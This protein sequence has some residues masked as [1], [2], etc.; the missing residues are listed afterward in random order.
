MKRIS[1]ILLVIVLALGSFS[2]AASLD[3]PSQAYIAPA[4]E[5]MSLPDLYDTVAPAVVFIQ[6]ESNLGNDFSDI[7]PSQGLG[8]GFVV[9]SSGHIVTNNHVIEGATEI[10]VTFFDGTLSRAEI[11]GTD[12]DSDLAVIRADTVPA[13]IVPVKLGDSGDIRVGEEVVAI[14][15]PF[16]QNWTMTR[17]IISALGR[18]NRATTGFSIPLMIQTDAAMNPGNSGGPLVDMRG[19][20]IGVN[21]MIFSEDRV[22]SGVGFS[23]PVNT[24]SRVVPELIANGRYDYTWIGISGGDLTLDI[25]E[26]LGLPDDVRGVLISRI[27]Q[28]GPAQGSDLTEGDIII[29]I[30]GIS[31]SGIDELIAYLAENTRPNDIINVTILRDGSEQNISVTLQARPDR[32]R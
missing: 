21:T 13:N 23:V 32:A 26:S 19:Q 28:G 15:S 24:V 25:L 29:A 1:L 4:Q 20:V 22:S 8:S 17:G 27:S 7:F 9:D 11:I 18:A 30:D 6:V 12:P 14:G 10:T 16:G 3:D 31:I 5:E 2:A